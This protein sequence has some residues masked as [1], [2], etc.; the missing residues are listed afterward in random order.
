MSLTAYDAPH[1]VFFWCRRPDKTNC[2]VASSLAPL[3]ENSRGDLQNRSASIDVPATVRLSPRG[4]S[5]AALSYKPVLTFFKKKAPP[6]LVF[7]GNTCVPAGDKRI[8]ARTVAPAGVT[9]G[10]QCALRLERVVC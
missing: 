6:S 2:V 7:D 5:E 4:R 1:R 9:R 10:K 8:A 3:A